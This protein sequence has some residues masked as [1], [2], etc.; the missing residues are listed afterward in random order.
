M[1]MISILAIAICL[2]AV[3]LFILFPNLAWATDGM[4]SD[5]ARGLCCR[6]P[7]GTGSAKHTPIQASGQDQRVLPRRVTPIRRSDFAEC[8]GFDRHSQP[9]SYSPALSALSP[10]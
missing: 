9:C 1:K 7:N 5:S 3:A 4:A 2:L 8:Q 10:N 6:V